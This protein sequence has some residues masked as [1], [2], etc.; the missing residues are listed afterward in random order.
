V[1]LS[2]WQI[3]DAHTRLAQSVSIVQPAPAM[4][5]AQPPPPQSVPVSVPAFMPSLQVSSW[6]SRSRQNP[7]LQSLGCAHFARWS[8]AGQS[9]PPQ[10]TS[11]SFP[12]TTLSV[13]L[14]D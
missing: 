7:V 2:T 3:D 10:S 11:V 1:Q 14:A 13:Q 5:G 8:H 9:P 6:Q 12:L 4:Q